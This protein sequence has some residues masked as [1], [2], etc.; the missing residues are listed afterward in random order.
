MDKPGKSA[1][2]GVQSVEVAGKLLQVLLQSDGPMKLAEI[3]AEVEMPSAKV[4]RYLVSLIR[5]GFVQQS[6]ES[7]KYDLGPIAFQLGLKGFA[8]FEPL[9]LAEYM[10]QELVELVGETA[11]LAVWT[12]K[13]ATMIRVI[14]AR[15]DF[16]TTIAPTHH[17]PMTFSATGVLFSSY[18]DEVRTEPLIERELEQNRISGR[19][20]SPL[21]RAELDAMIGATT[22][23]G[24][25]CMT[26][27]GGDGFGAVSAPVFDVTGKLVMAVT[28]FGRSNRVDATADG[29]LARIV[30]RTAAKISA[31]FGYVTP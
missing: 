10:L 12:A 11:A 18:E 5:T 16:A 4:H 23:R 31:A 25:S 3:A 20:N 26:D 15:H 19:P 24:Y 9:K 6:K 2:G 21:D 27:G 22:A 14:E 17:C 1:R 7:S 30:A 29:T 13:G 28:V 8:R